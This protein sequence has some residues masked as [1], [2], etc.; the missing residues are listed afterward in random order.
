[1]GNEL[2]ADTIGKPRLPMPVR[3]VQAKAM[4]RYKSAITIGIVLLYFLLSG[5][6]G[7]T[8]V[9]RLESPKIGYPTVRVLLPFAD[10]QYAIK[11]TGRYITRG[12]TSTGG[13]VTYYC[14]RPVRLEAHHGRWTLSERK[15]T[16][17]ETDLVKVTMYAKDP[18]D[19]L[20]INGKPYPGSL[21]FHISQDNGEPLVV[22][23]ANLDEYLV[24]VLPPE[25]GKRTADE[26]EAVKAQA[27][28]ARTYALSHLG[29][30]KRAEYDLRADH[31]DQVYIGLQH[32]YDWV[33]KAV[34][35]TIG[36]V[37]RFNGNLIEA[38]YHSTC[39]GRTDDIAS[40]WGKDPVPYL[41]SAD[42]DTFCRWSRYAN[43]SEEW[44]SALLKRN[45][46][47]YL[48]TVDIAPFREFKDILTIRTEGRTKGGRIVEMLITT[49]RGDWR[50]PTDQIRWALGRPST[51]G[52]ILE[53]ANCELLP[54]YS[55]DGTLVHLT[56]VGTGYGHG[57]G[58]CQCGMIG[59]A[60]AGQT[61][62]Q[63]LTHYYSGATIEKIY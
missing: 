61:Y 4:I 48:E 8:R 33:K 34:N 18:D 2:A 3:H 35:E 28:A 49:D 31:H 41:V 45:L 29:Q 47:T 10:T 50:I 51:D 58:M 37:L 43:W 60:R 36:E 55:T 1:M 16:V 40:V 57:V 62:R 12:I 14:S 6:G 25:L 42:D 32:P 7:P 23:H 19:H 63:I 53:S 9:Q 17:L 5:C 59:R 39:G 13:E 52:P 15:K 22:N 38:Y 30:Y 27:V 44:D 11:G 21:I 46:R 24:G 26:F 20:T 56:A 54:K